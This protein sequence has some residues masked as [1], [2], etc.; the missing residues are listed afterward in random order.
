MSST[1]CQ[2]PCSPGC[3]L[4]SWSVCEAELRLAKGVIDRLSCDQIALPY[5]PVDHMWPNGELLSQQWDMDSSSVHWNHGMTKEAQ[6]GWQGTS[7]GRSRA[8]CCPARTPASLQRMNGTICQE[9]RASWPHSGCWVLGTGVSMPVGNSATP[10]LEALHRKH[11]S[12][13]WNSHL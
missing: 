12:Q 5:P 10:F 4:P 2:E 13:A 7:D 9:R 6:C 1:G 8:V 3:P 11:Q